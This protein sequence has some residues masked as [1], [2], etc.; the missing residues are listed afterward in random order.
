[1][2]INILLYDEFET[3]DAFGP[4]EILGEVEDFSLHYYSPSGGMVKSAH[5]VRVMTAPL[6]EIQPEGVLFIPGGYGAR[7]LMQDEAFLARLRALAEDACCCLTVCTGSALLAK[8]GVL[9]MKKATTNKQLFDWVA[10]NNADVNWQRS[11]RWVTDGKFY[12]SSG[13]TAGMDM[14]LGFIADSL[15]MDKAYQIAAYIEYVWNPDPG[16]DPFA[17]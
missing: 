13:V 14:T 6:A 11:A 15:D 2:D 9:D 3:L 12:T 16:D 4:A 17:V 5:G 8:T 7:A 1:M 10:E